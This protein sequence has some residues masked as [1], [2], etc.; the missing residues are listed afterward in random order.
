MG[1]LKT[2][3]LAGA[4]LAGAT[5]VASAADLRGPVGLPPAPI[6]APIVEASGWYLRG[7][8][9][10]AALDARKFN[11]SDNPQGLSFHGKDF[12]SQFSGGIGV[13]YQYNS[14]FRFD[15]TGEYRS[16]TGFNVNDKYSLRNVGRDCA[17]GINAA[18]DCVFSGGNRNSG[19][20]GSMVF[21]ANAYVDL[22]TW[23][24]LSPFVGAGIGWTQNRTAGVTDQGFAT[25]TLVNTGTNTTIVSATSPAYGTAANGTKS[26]LAYAFMAGVGYEV[27]PNYKVE[28]AYRYLNL[29]KFQTG[30]YDCAGGCAGTYTLQGKN[31]EA[32]EFRVG[33]R[34]LLGGPTYAAPAYH[35][36][37]VQKKF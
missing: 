14:W 10:I 27:T 31:L 22:G 23:H 35:P 19:T 25:Q 12:G 26:G 7:D 13:G 17:G 9:G 11:Y 3:A 29:G 34:W 21:L 20:I 1:S 33:M 37:Y 30:V 4:A 24:G 36:P 8:V 28:L 18:V 6:A 32:H 15:L 2:L 5:A 16:R